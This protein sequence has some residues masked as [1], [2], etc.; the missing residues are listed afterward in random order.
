MSYNL[1]YKIIHKRKK[2]ANN[3]HLFSVTC[4][5]VTMQNHKYYNDFFELG[6]QKINY[7]VNLLNFYN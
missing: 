7:S 4:Y 1:P 5:N 3:N 6:Q 2:M